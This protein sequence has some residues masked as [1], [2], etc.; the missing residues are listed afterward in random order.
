MK[1][2]KTLPVLIEKYSAG[3][4]NFSTLQRTRQVEAIAVTGQLK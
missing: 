2:N 3:G 4:R 1:T